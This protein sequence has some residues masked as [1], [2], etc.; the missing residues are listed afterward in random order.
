MLK[1]LSFDVADLI[2]MRNRS[3]SHGLRMV[4]QL[5]HGSDVDEYEEVLAFH[6][7]TS[8]QCRW[9]MWRNENTVFVRSNED[10]ARRYGSVTQAIDALVRK[11]PAT[12]PYTKAKQCE[13]AIQTLADAIRETVVADVDPCVLMGTLVE[14]AVY[15]LATRIAAVHQGDTAA[16]LSQ[17]LTDRLEQYRL[18]R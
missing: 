3:E 5:D 16:A 15:T 18:L 7:E 6:A 8:P 17:L 2:L 14:A 11:L 13:P 9:L 12:S 4:V 10:R 1:G